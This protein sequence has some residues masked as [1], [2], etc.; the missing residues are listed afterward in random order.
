[1]PLND[2]EQ[3]ILDEIE[4]QLYEGDPKLAKIVA[5]AVR[6]GADRWKTRVAGAVF[7]L[8]AVLMFVSFTMSVVVAGVG[9][10]VMVVSAGWLVLT[11]VPAGLGQSTSG[12]V[13]AW[14]NRL[15]HRRH[16]DG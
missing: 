1:M 8:G 4:R 7:L 13:D 2:H 11:T 6:G 12:T 9:F 14:M 3:E 10:L 16:E 15:Q 5:N